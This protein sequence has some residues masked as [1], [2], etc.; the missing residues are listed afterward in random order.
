MTTDARVLIERGRAALAACDWG[1]ARA[2]FEQAVE[3][4]Q[5]AAAL[6]GLGQALYWQGEYARALSL[7]ERGYAA[8]RRE[9][10]RRDA[11]RVAVE[12][13]ALHLWVHG[14]KAACV[15]WTEHARRLLQ[16]EGD[17]VER[18]WLQLLLAV[19]AAGDVHEWERL[20]RSAV[21]FGRRFDDAGLEYDALG[22]VGLALVHQGDIADGMRLIDEAV[23]A[24][25]S[26]VVADPW[27]AGEIYCTLFGACELA[28]DVRRAEAWLAAVD[29][30]VDRT[31]ELP[32]SAICRM[33]YGGLLVSAGRWDD[34]EHEL[35][36]ALDLY[37][38]TWRGSRFEPVVRLA[39]LRVRQGRLAE[40]R[41]LLQGFEGLPD[42]AAALARVHL[43]GGEP[44]LAVRVIERSLSRRGRGLA[45]VTLLGL[46]VEAMLADGRHEG[47]AEVALELDDLARATGQLAV[48]GVASMAAARVAIARSDERAVEL[49]ERAIGA[50]AEAT[51]PYELARTRLALAQTVVTADPEL[52]RAEAR[53]AMTCFDELRAARDAD[54]AA[55]L[56]RTL[57]DRGRPRS[58]SS[59]ALTRRESQV[60]DLLAQG[61]SNAGIAADLH[62]SLRTAEDHVSNILAKLGLANRTEA[63]AYALRSGPDR[64][65]A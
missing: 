5:S 10:S 27:P 54:A 41:Q 2:C 9:E 1:A 16:P 35:V 36:A 51:L 4:S 50:F 12:L 57:G 18:G 43:V 56:L 38:R 24:A 58:T 30:Y 11:G 6:D 7:R 21:E 46:L 63:A 33:H 62:I 22:H 53:A 64:R 26:G 44:A 59:G 32:V 23:A 37:E 47:A 65:H 13:A 45:S 17:C 31:G 3:V 52:A 55:A 8:Y 39:D 28:I 61:R 29:G 14:N 15:G 34:A 20:A 49:L 48:E 42:A 40:A 19:T 25:S 60:L